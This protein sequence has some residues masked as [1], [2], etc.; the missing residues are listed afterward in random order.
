MEPA[1]YLQTLMMALIYARPREPMMPLALC[2]EIWKELEPKKSAALDD[3]IN[4]A[5]P[6]N[7]NPGSALMDRKRL[8]GEVWIYPYEHEGSGN[9]R[10]SHAMGPYGW[11]PG[12]PVSEEVWLLIWR[13]LYSSYDDKG[14]GIKLD[15]L[16]RK[17][18]EERISPEEMEKAVY[19]LRFS[20]LMLKVKDE[21]LVDETFERFRHAGISFKPQELQVGVF[22]RGNPNP[23]RHFDKLYSILLDRLPAQGEEGSVIYTPKPPEEGIHPAL[24]NLFERFPI[25]AKKLQTRRREGKTG[26]PALEDEYDTQHLLHALLLEH[27]SLVIDEDPTAKH[28]TKSSTFDFRLPDHSIGIEVKH[29]RAS[30]STSKLRKELIQDFEEYRAQKEV[31]YLYCFVYDP[32]GRYTMDAE[33]IER[34]LTGNKGSFT[35]YVFVRPK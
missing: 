18:Q 8:H 34:D 14:H 1:S 21:L 28:G 23:H 6:R 4:A 32:D 29:A 30:L 11:W 25:I 26:L 7:Y 2:K 19:S 9:Q 35:A 5:S 31:K 16:Y 27:A 3:A 24:V 22:H 17:G 15:E 33:A 12:C 20:D 10:L 13:E